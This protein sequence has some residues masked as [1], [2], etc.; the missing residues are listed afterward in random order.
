[1]KNQVFSPL[2]AK[3]AS[4]ALEGLAV[5]AQAMYDYHNQSKIVTPKMNLLII[6]TEKLNIAEA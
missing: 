6:K 3:G 1:M 2:I 4:K 5:W